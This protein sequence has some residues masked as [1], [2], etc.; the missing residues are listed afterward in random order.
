MKKSWGSRIALLGLLALAAPVGAH[1]SFAMFDNAKD[2]KLEGTVKEF[3]WTN[4]HTWIQLMVT[5]PD[6]KVT[7]WSIE[8]SSPNGLRR[9]GWRAETI[10]AGDK[11]TV[12]IHPLKSGEPGGSLVNVTL[13]DGKVMGRQLPPPGQTSGD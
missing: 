13:P 10:K 8:G 9:Q 5:A 11:V 2:M 1:H 12:N 4:P 3:Q 6:G 7:E